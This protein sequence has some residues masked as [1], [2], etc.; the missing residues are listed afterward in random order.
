[1]HDESRLHGALPT[2]AAQLDEIVSPSGQLEQRA[3]R[4][5]RDC[6]ARSGGLGRGEKIAAPGGGGARSTEHALVDRL[7]ALADPISDLP[8]G[9]LDTPSVCEREHAVRLAGESGELLVD[10]DRDRL[11]RT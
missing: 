9:E 1:M 3:R 6:R 7:P 10:I 11:P 8:F 5:M 4:A 2:D